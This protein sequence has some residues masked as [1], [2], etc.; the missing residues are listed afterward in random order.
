MYRPIPCIVGD[1]T[2]LE[3]EARYD[4]ASRRWNIN[5][6]SNTPC[7]SLNVSLIVGTLKARGTF[8]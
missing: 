2:F 3:D 5:E 4:K 1:T 7:N 8:E 6:P